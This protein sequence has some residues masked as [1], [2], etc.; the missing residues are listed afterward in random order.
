MSLSLYEIRWRIE[1]ILERQNEGREFSMA[2]FG[3][4]TS[5][6]KKPK[7]DEIKQDPKA[8]SIVAKSY[9]LAKMRMKERYGRKASN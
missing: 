9:Q 3:Y 8:D 4:D 6:M 2:L 1:T 5:K 7:Q